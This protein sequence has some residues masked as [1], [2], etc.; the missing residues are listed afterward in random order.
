[1]EKNNE[2]EFINKLTNLRNQYYS[3]T[4][5]NVFFKNKQKMEC[6]TTICNSIGLEQ[7]IDKTIYC[8]QNSNIVF[9]D[10]TI[11]K[12]YA[13]PENYNQI[14]S[15]ALLMCRHKI[16]E[17][18][19]FEIHINLNSF[20]VSAC[21]RYKD[22]IQIFCNECLRSNT[23]YSINLSKLIVYN[24]PNMIDSIS[25]IILPFIDPIVRNKI[26]LYNKN[27]SDS[28]LCNLFTNSIELT[29]QKMAS[30]VSI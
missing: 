18:G 9:F 14:V 15:H 21:E 24:S 22:I 7:I 17:H 13:T 5:R 25:R 27:E 8:I 4:G 30:A 1:M 16:S 28:L 6:A 23:R 19:K 29:N 3:D 2:T 10:Y 12:M 11:F 20:T 26:T